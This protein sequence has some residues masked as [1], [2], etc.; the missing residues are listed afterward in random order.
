[1][2]DLRKVAGIDQLQNGVLKVEIDGEEILLIK[3]GEKIYA[4]SNICSHQEKELSSGFLENGVWVCPHH[5]ARFDIKTGEALSMP[6]V[7]GIKSYKVEIKGNDIF[8]E[9]EDE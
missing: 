8:I 5:G 3:D 4:L 2:S 1:M 6:A 7:E 9:M